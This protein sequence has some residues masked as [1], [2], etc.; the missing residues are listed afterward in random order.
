MTDGERREEASERGSGVDAG[1][2]AGGIPCPGKPS[3]ACAPPTCTS[4]KAF[5]RTKGV[6]HDIVVYEQ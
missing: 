6:S 3:M 5:R 4:T 2:R 1:R